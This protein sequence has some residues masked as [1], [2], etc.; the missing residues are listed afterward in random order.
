MF[1]V[2]ILVIIIFPTTSF[3]Q[4][5]D[6][7][8]AIPSTKTYINYDFQAPYPK[9]V[10]L[11]CKYLCQSNEH[12]IEIRAKRTVRITNQR[13]EGLDVVCQGV[14]VKEGR[15]G[16]EFD[17]VEPFFAYDTKMKEIR[18]WA[19]QVGIEID[20]PS[21]NVLMNN[22][23]ENFKLVSSSYNIAG[24][25]NTEASFHFRE[26]ALILDKILEELPSDKSSLDY[27]TNKL[28]ASDGQ[29][30]N[31]FSSENLVL[32]LVLTFGKWRI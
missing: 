8:L 23:I 15:W 7:C 9:D 25:T 6:H 22:L 26:A 32:R 19:S 17:R 10:T 12:S 28:R 30:S 29:I 1:K 20:G 2:L 31:E 18:D 13:S 3:S 16:H 11:S 27:Y 24:N 5:L 14:I 4:V 21:S